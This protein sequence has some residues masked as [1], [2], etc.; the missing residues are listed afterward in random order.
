MVESQPVDDQE[1]EVAAELETAG[2]GGTAMAVFYDRHPEVLEGVVPKP[3]T[4]VGGPIQKGTSWEIN[5]DAS[6]SG[7]HI[8]KPNR[9]LIMTGI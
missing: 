6:V 1:I 4:Q 2:P 9:V 8:S 5:F 7:V 3:M